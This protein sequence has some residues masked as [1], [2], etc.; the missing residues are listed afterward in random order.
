MYCFFSSK[1]AYSAVANYG[2]LGK[3]HGLH[4]NGYDIT[5]YYSRETKCIFLD[6]LL[7]CIRGVAAQCYHLV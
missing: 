7:W 6:L 1:P 5:G 4:S 3:N 2:I